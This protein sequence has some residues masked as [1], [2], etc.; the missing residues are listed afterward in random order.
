MVLINFVPQVGNKRLLSNGISVEITSTQELA[1]NSKVEREEGELSPNGDFEEDNFAVYEKTG[2]ETT[3]KANDNIGNNISGDRSREGEPSCL[4]TGA[5]NDAEGDENAARSSEDSR[6][7]YENGDV[8]GTES[9]GGEGPEDDLDRNCKGDSE[10]EAEGMAD[11]HDA[12][13][14]G[15]AL[16]FSARFL[17]HVKPLAKYVP[18]TIALHDKDKDSLK[19]S[20]VFYGNDSFYVLFRLHRVRAKNHI[21]FEKNINSKI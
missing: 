18:S 15:S 10:C 21:Q 12:E 13:E 4:E 7:A 9:G 19:N 17:L 5:E 1:G 6:N 8:S 14:D 16:P 11:A 3:S 20:Q 2:L